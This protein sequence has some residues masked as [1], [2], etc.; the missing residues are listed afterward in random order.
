MRLG[1]GFAEVEAPR[2]KTPAKMASGSGREL[3]PQL[4][5]ILTACPAVAGRGGCELPAGLSSNTDGG[6]KPL[7]LLDRSHSLPQLEG[8]A[9]GYTSAIEKR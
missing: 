6:W 9:P 4:G 2:P 3:R 8:Y 5:P 1:R 7:A